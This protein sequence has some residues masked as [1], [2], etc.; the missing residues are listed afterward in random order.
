ML[1]DCTHT[2]TQN[3]GRAVYLSSSPHTINKASQPNTHSHTGDFC[4]P[5]SGPDRQSG[6]ELNEHNMRREEKRE[7]EGGRGMWDRKKSEDLDA[8]EK[9][10][11][12]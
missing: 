10:R 8:G 9:V 7:R 3:A 4:H 5:F 2:H 11:N 1:F 12:V 6:P